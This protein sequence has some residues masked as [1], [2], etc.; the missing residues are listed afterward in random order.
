MLQEASASSN[1]KIIQLREDIES[2][3][4]QIAHLEK[5]NEKLAS[6]TALASIREKEMANAFEEEKMAIE[7]S[8]AIYLEMQSTLNI[9]AILRD[10][11]LGLRSVR[12]A[13]LIEKIAWA[14]RRQLLCMKYCQ[15]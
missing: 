6:A 3:F 13:K 14:R 7:C 11:I 9:I 4:Q 5:E 1:V 15:Y 10:L 2:K 12:I 8:F